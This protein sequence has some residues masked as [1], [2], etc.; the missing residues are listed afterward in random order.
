VKESR[1]IFLPGEYIITD[2]Q[3]PYIKS[4]S[5]AR[6]SQIFVDLVSRRV[7]T[8]GLVDKTDS[9]E[10]IRKIL[11]DARSRSG[12]PVKVLRTDGDGIF[13]KSGSFQKL[14][15]EFHFIHEQ[16]PAYDHNKSAVV[17]RECRTLLEGTATLLFQSGAPPSMWQEAGAYFVFVRN[18]LPRLETET[19]GVFI[20]SEEKLRGIVK[21]FV[22]NNFVPFGAQANC[23]IPPEKR[24]PKTPG[25]KKSFEGA[26]VGISEDCSAYRVFD[27]ETKKIRDISFSFCVVS[28]GCFPFRARKKD[29]EGDPVSFFPTMEAFLTPHEWEKYKFSKEQQQDVIKRKGLVSIPPPPPRGEEGK[30]EEKK[31]ESER[32]A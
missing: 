9:D 14:K 18:R 7:W 11:L 25:Q 10:A 16:S 2:L 19:V 1:E 13:G 26:I 27:L 24:G 20:S 21:P 32:K 6:Y 29:F 15:E 23:L 17:D 22:L 31:S 30:L 8:V 28:E 5:G 3:G 12:R 4:R